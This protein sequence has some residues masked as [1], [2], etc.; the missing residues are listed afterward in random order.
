MAK[1][2]IG[3][4]IEITAGASLLPVVN[5]AI[6]SAGLGNIGSATQTLVGVGFLGNVA[7]KT[8]KGFKF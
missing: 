1:K 2:I 6:G 4:F 7:K 5:S 8:T 3:D